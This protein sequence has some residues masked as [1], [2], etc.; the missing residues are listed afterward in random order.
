MLKNL[1]SKIKQN[2]KKLKES[3]KGWFAHQEKAKK[4]G[5]KKKKDIEKERKKKLFFF[6]ENNVEN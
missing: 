5:K 4:G 6:L 2:L 1:D 3:R